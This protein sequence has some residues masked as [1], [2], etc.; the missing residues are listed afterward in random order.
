[1]IVVR[2]LAD[3]RAA[4]EGLPDELGL[5]PTMGFLHDGHLSLVRASKDQCAA[6]AV[7]IF[8]NPSQFGPGVDLEN[9]PR[10]LERDLDLLRQSGVNLVWTP[11]EA[12]LYPPEFQTWVEVED[13][14]R[15]LEGAHRPGHFRGVTTIVAMLLN[16]IQPQKAFFGQKDAQQVV[17]IRRMIEDLLFPA[18]LVVQPTVREP[19]GL[20]MSSRNSYLNPAERSAATVLYRGLQRAVQAFQ[21]GVSS[22]GAL[23]EIMAAELAREPLAQVDYVSVAS[24]ETLEELEGDLESGLL[25]MA[26]GIGETRLIDNMIVGA[27][28]P[29]WPS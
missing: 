24:L 22:A 6:T 27:T 25:A 15:P 10:N 1:M 16:A 28:D 2:S 12:D 29:F 21:K 23:R 18:R 4:R 3:L 14:S 26:V 7:S 13:L 5:V 9:Y 19:D 20:A 11:N 17:V 8:V